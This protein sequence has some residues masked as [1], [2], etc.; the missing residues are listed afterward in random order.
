MNPLLEY[1]LESGEAFWVETTGKH[2]Y[3]YDLK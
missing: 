3:I 2:I 1:T